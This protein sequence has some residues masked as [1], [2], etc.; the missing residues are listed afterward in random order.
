M[1]LTEDQHAVE[2][3]AAQ[4]TEQALAGRVHPR[5]LDSGLQDP[6]AA[7][8]EDGVEDRVKFDPRSRI[9]NRI[10]SNRSP[11]ARA[12]LRACCTVHSPVRFAVTPPRCIRRVP[13]SMNTRTYSRFSSTVS[14][15]KKSTARIPGGLGV[16]ELPPGRA[17]AA[18]RRAD[19]RT[20]QDVIDGGRSDRD[21][22]LGQLAVDPAVAPQRILFC[23]ADYE[24]GDAA[25]RWRAAGLAPSA[26][27]VLSRG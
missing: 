5:S 23:Q 16:Q 7:C 9:K 15:C 18:L 19:A 3:L 20:S 12:R 25:N 8:L 13:C 27:V 10:C 26:R 21:A 24:A 1:C 22:E 11:R 6:G 17:C 4:G 2:E 14:T